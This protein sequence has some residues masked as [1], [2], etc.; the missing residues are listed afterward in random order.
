MCSTRSAFPPH[1]LCDR[2]LAR[3]LILDGQWPHSHG[4]RRNETLMPPDASHAFRIW[5]K[6][7]Y[8]T[9]LI[10]K[11]HCFTAPSDLALFDTFCEISHGGLPDDPTTKGMDWFRP[12]KGIRAAA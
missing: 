11:N 5:K 2:F 9:G 1:P 3:N 7:G 4:G 12:I 6:A 10:G 8:H